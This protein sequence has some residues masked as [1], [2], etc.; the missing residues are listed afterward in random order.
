MVLIK[1]GDKEG[2][3]PSDFI[4]KLSQGTARQALPNSIVSLEYLQIYQPPDFDPP[5]VFEVKLPDEQYGFVTESNL[6]ESKT[7]EFVFYSF[8]TLKSKQLD[9][10]A[11][12]LDYVVKK[13]PSRASQHSPINFSQKPFRTIS[14]STSYS[15][16]TSK[17]YHSSSSEFNTSSSTEISESP[18]SPLLTE[19]PNIRESQ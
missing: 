10:A 17:S 4:F 15:S 1:E 16:A 8:K 6:K 12:K 3:V 19:R 11:T 2:F 5:Q 18:E 7:I 14:S 9:P 13:S